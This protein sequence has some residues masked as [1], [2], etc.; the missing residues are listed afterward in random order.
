MFYLY[1]KYP[2]KPALSKNKAVKGPDYV[3]STDMFSY[4]MIFMLT[5]SKP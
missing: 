2:D 3:Y 4:T 5:E 1:G